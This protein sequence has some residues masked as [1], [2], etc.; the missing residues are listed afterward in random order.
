MSLEIAFRF[1]LAAL[2]TWRLSFML[3]R[4]AG[5]GNVWVSMRTW[6]GSGFLGRLLKCVKCV[7]VWVAIPFAF[8]VG[9]SRIELLVTWWALSGVSALI[10]EFTKPPFEFRETSNDE[11]LR[12]NDNDPL[13]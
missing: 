12:S 4:E 13:N 11:L 10:D 6:A 2:A 1:L 9:G 8:F 5:P 7:S 3:V